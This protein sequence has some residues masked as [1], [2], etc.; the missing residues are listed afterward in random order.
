[1]FWVQRQRLR[2]DKR[3]QRSGDLATDTFQRSLGLQLTSLASIHSPGWDSQVFS[4]CLQLWPVCRCYFFTFI[5]YIFTISP[6]TLVWSRVAPSVIMRTQISLVTKDLFCLP[7]CTSR[8]E[9][10]QELSPVLI[11]L[12]FTFTL[13]VASSLPAR[14]LWSLWFFFEITLFFWG[15]EGFSSRDEGFNLCSQKH[16]MHFVCRS[17][18]CILTI[19]YL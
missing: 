8:A 14:T 1:M 12:I 15:F 5:F 17:H 11:Q 9:F 4:L 7:S 3:E 2:K 18:I 10:T 6:F 16:A 13:E 19:L